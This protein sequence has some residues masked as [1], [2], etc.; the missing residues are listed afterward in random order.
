[1]HVALDARMLGASLHGLGRY[2]YALTDELARQA[3]TDRFTLLGA[4]PWAERLAA[5]HANVDVVPVRARPFAPAEQVELPRL[6]RSLRPDLFHA[7]SAAVPLVRPVPWCITVPDLIPLFFGG[8]KHRFYFRRYL[9]GIVRRA[10]GVLVFSEATRADLTRHLGIAAERVTV[11]PLGVDQSFTP[12]AASR[13][14]LL[15]MRDR[16]G[17]STPYVFVAANPRP[18]KNLPFAMQ[19]LDFLADISAE[20]AL[21]FVLLSRPGPALLESVERMRHRTRLLW[22]HE[23]DEADLAALYRHAHV[24]FYP[25]LYEGFGLPVLEALASG[26]VVVC[27]DAASLPEIVGEAGLLVDARDAEGCRDALLRA[28]DDMA[29]R[30]DLLERGPLRAAEFTWTKTARATLQVYRNAVRNA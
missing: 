24:F 30:H 21:T 29:L 10:C 5:T 16:L 28:C 1:M 3:P 19:V 26:A 15:R 8:A 6:L 25:S 14:E 7:T 27:S 18:H 20:S 9:P 13:D 17:V 2:V 11:A 12:R 22:L 4:S 23:V